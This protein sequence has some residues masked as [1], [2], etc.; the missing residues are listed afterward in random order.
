MS[1]NRADQ[2]SGPRHIGNPTVQYIKGKCCSS[3]SRIAYRIGCTC[4][5]R[6]TASHALAMWGVDFLPSTVPRPRDTE[7]DTRFLR[8]LQTVAQKVFLPSC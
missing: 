7:F 2:Y 3:D 4:I 6:P 5:F 1:L 8:R